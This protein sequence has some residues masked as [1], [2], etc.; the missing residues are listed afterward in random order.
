MN[1]CV[2]KGQSSPPDGQSNVQDPDNAYSQFIDDLVYSVTQD[3]Q[4]TREQGKQQP[5]RRAHR[6]ARVLESG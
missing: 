1:L 2:A 4:A 6:R 5:S 3:F